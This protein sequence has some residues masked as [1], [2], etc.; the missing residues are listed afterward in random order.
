MQECSI[1]HEEKQLKA[2]STIIMQSLFYDFGAFKKRI[3]DTKKTRFF[4]LSSSFISFEEGIFRKCF[5]NIHDFLRECLLHINEKDIRAM[6][7]F[8]FLVFN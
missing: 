5:S 2:R 1:S 8:L 7:L 6:K 4:F 3:F